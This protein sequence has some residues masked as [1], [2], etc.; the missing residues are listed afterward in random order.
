MLLKNRGSPLTEVMT[1]KEKIRASGYF[2][3]RKTAEKMKM[4][5]FL[6]IASSRKAN[7]RHGVEGGSR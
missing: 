7:V 1:K 3:R 4:L 6:E 5:R 2:F